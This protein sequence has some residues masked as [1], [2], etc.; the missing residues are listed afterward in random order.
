MPAL[1]ITYDSKNQW[2]DYGRLIRA[3]KSYPWVRLT[4]YCYAI[5]TKESP[6]AV[7]D[8]LRAILD[9]SANLYVLAL[10]KPFA[11]F[12]PETVN[13]WLKKNLPGDV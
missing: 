10:K 2:L 12:G 13:D 5:T 9:D 3:I 4:D 8:K 7:F 11:G 6:Q 1:L